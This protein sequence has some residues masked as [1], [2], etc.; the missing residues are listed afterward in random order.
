MFPVVLADSP[1]PAR[2]A[3]SPAPA[4][5]VHV[6]DDELRALLRHDIMFPLHGIDPA[7]LHDTFIEARPGRK[8]HEALDI[9]ARR[10]T[11]IH[12]VDDG[13]IARL[14]DN[15]RG[16]LCIYQIDNNGSFCYFY[17]H[18]DRYTNRL[19]AGLRVKRGDIIGYVGSTGDARASGPHLHF[20]I[21]RV[22]PG[23]MWWAGAPIDPYPIF[24][25]L[26]RHEFAATD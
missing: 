18:L 25:G 22:V 8:A 20:A 2:V 24:A 5:E 17:A 19:K 23:E 12:A 4:I 14:S 16:G 1:A 7:L 3:P 21:S 13:I 26:S 6:A 11:P 10:G 9:P 15:A